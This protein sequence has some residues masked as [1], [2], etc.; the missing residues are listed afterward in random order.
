M[1]CAAF[2][3]AQKV[4]TVD[5]V[6]VIQNNSKPKAPKGIPTKITFQ[7]EL[8]VGGGDD[9]ET[10]FSEVGLFVVSDDGAIY[11]L[12]MKARNIKVYD[13]E[14]KFVRLI[15]KPGQG[16]GELGIPGGILLTPENELMVLDASNRSLSYFTLEGD[17]IRNLSIADKL[18][19]ILIVPDGRGNLAGREMGFAEGEMYFE[20]KKFDQDLKPLFT[21][22]KVKFKPP[23]PGSGNK[24]NLMDMINMYAFDR[25]G[26]LYYG[27]NKEYEIQAFDDQGQHFLSIRKEYKKVKVTQEDIDEIMER[28][29]AFGGA[30]GGVNIADLFEFPDHFPPYRTFV[31]DEAGRMFVT[32]WEKGEKKGDFWVD[33]FDRE[34]RYFT[35][36]LTKIETSLWK[37]GKAYAIVENEDGF[38]VIK[39]F[40]VTWS[41]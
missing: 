28:M 24:I 11:G 16:P 31:F 39:R 41:Q 22:S 30:A 37:N 34:G 5:G 1:T 7:E 21:V 19:L 8:S 25:E 4:K 23:V 15:G 10:S 6:K 36:F 32:T 18:G 35:R 26:N 38:R 20:L 14:G 40:G 29:A 3:P 27:H 9:P 2:L 17:H 13:A 12:D 33:V